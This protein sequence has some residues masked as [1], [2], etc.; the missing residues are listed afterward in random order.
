MRKNYSSLQRKFSQ[1]F[2]ETDLSQMIRW[3]KCAMF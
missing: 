1:I 3:H 2:L